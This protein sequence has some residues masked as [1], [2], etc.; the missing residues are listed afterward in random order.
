MKLYQVFQQYP[1]GTIQARGREPVSKREAE[2]G[3]RK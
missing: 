2:L 1:D 3:Y